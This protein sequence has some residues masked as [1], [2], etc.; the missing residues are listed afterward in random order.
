[1]ELSRNTVNLDKLGIEL[2]GGQ[3]MYKNYAS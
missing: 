1:M 3:S 2:Y